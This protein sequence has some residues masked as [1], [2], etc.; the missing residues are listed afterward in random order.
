MND[1]EMKEKADDIRRDTLLY[2]LEKDV[3][4][5]RMKLSQLTD[6][7]FALEEDDDDLI[8]EY[9]LSRIAAWGSF[10]LAGLGTLF[11]IMAV[12]TVV[13]AIV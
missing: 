9:S 11:F 5:T 13:A 7:V 3:E 6:R 4:M 8:Y 2:G 10:A 1:N 12:M